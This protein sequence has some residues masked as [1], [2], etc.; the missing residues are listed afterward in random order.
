MGLTEVQYRHSPGGLLG[1]PAA[2]AEPPP[3]A[4]PDEHAAPVSPGMGQ[5]HPC[6]SAVS[7]VTA[8]RHRALPTA[9]AMAHLEDSK[10]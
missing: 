7:T 10:P 8:R 1:R 3:P 6:P 9:P 4:S 2:T 5:G